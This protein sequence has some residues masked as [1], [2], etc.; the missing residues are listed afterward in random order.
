MANAFDKFTERAR[1]VLTL[2]GE[3]AQRLNHNYIGS[4]HLL[5][6]LVREGDGVAARVLTSL[7]VRLPVLRE[8]VRYMIGRGEGLVVGV[9]GLTPRAKRVIELAIDEARRLN[10]HYIGTEHLLLGLVREGGSV[11]VGVL[12]TNGVNLEKVR[13]QV[14]EVVNQSGGSGLGRLGVGPSGWPALRELVRVIPIAQTLQAD[15]IQITLVSLEIYSD[16]LLLHLYFLL[17]DTE[18]FEAGTA[19]IRADAGEAPS[20]QYVGMAQEREH[21]GRQWRWVICYRPA[22]AA[23]VRELE[24]AI[25]KLRWRP[26]GGEERTLGPWTFAITL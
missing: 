21:Y 16:G 5:L 15:T 6:G 3:E 17:D 13:T 11:G 23:G 26:S 1:K 20:I 7:G 14:M 2:A 12:E 4:E 25:P 10:H 9:V 19:D 24:I 18:A 22:P 8:S